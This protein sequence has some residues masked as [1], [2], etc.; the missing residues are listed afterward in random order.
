MQEY[1]SHPA[2]RETRRRTMVPGADSRAQFPTP[3]CNRSIAELSWQSPVAAGS[4]WSL[5]IETAGP[6]S[7]RG[8]IYP[9]SREMQTVFFKKGSRP[10]RGSSEG[11]RKEENK[12]DRPNADEGRNR[13][14]TA[15]CRQSRS[16]QQPGAVTGTKGRPPGKHATTPCTTMSAVGSFVHGPMLRRTRWCDDANGKQARVPTSP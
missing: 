2:P 10:P 11:G 8:T 14:S 12:S 6:L 5:K 16:V 7:L 3:R 15:Q 9:F 13:S 1:P 4:E